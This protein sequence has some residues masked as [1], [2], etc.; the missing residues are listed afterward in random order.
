M[1]N[2]FVVNEPEGQKNLLDD[3]GRLI[4]GECN[5][6]DDFFEQFTTFAQLGHETV[7]FWLIEDL[8]QLDHVR[9]I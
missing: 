8:V 5:F 2:S 6:P 1:H 4:L 7:P 3:G 9:M